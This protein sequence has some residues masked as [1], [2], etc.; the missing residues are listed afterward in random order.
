MTTLFLH[1]LD[2][3]QDFTAKTS[4]RWTFVPLSLLKESKLINQA[5][6]LVDCVRQVFLSKDLII[7][8]KK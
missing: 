2:K 3:N 8:S 7:K 4:W 5:T 1:L 6:A